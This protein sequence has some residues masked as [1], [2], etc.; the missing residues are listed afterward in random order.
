MPHMHYRTILKT[1]TGTAAG[2][3]ESIGDIITSADATDVPAI[4]VNAVNNGTTTTAEAVAAE[5]IINFRTLAPDT[6]RINVGHAIG[7]GPSTNIQAAISYPKWMSF[8]PLSSNVADKK[9]TFQ[10]DISI[11][12]TAE[13]SSSSSVV[14]VEG[15]YDED[16]VMNKG[17]NNVHT[18]TN[19]ADSAGVNAIGTAVSLAF[20]ETIT[21]PGWVDEI[22]AIGILV[23]PDAVFTHTEELLGYIEIG[24]TIPGLYP[25]E[26]PFPA[27]CSGIG[28][29][30]GSAVVCHEWILP[31]FIKHSSAADATLNLTGKLLTVTTGAN[32]INVT[33]YGRGSQG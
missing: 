9:I 20:D 26:I 29:P 28:T 7:G 11:E 15:E 16:V 13:T 25:M 21:V 10:A 30:V 19:W 12:S 2:T 22:V 1:A 14:F 6:I 33:L 5:Q 23:A 3:L 4:V 27:Q 24:G 31:L 18:R 8:L 17:L 32:H